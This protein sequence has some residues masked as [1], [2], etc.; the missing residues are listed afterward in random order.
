MR[1]MR[2]AL[3]GQDAAKE[4]AN[5]INQLAD[6]QDA[7]NQALNE[8]ANPEDL[9]EQ[10]EQ[11]AEQSAELNKRLSEMSTPNEVRLRIHA[12]SSSFLPRVQQK[13]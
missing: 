3:R 13:R 11:V 4:L 2:N 9:Q 12:R 8:G 7:I 1:E 10:Q 6:Q 5:A